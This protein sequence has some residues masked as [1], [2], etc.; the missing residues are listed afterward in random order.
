VAADGGQSSTDGALAVAD[1]GASTID[2]GVVGAD[3]GVA[4]QD[5]GLSENDSGQPVPKVVTGGCGCSAGVNSGSAFALIFPLALVLGIRRR[6]P[7]G[8]RSGPT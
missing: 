8:E 5:V 2:G 3:S 7:T 6:R 4:G 1:G